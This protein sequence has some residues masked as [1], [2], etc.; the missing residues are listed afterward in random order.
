MSAG[1]NRSGSEDVTGTKVKF[2]LQPQTT[3]DFKVYA[4]TSAGMGGSTPASGTV[5]IAGE[6]L[7]GAVKNDHDLSFAAPKSI[8]TPKK[9][10]GLV[11]PTFNLEEPSTAF[12]DIT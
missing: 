5:P 1:Y 4:Y 3:Y 8:P 9:V 12:G 6:T 2:D 7:L 10:P 11:P